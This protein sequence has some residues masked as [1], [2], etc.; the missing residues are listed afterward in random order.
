MEPEL[1][2]FSSH[3]VFPSVGLGYQPSHK[4][5]TTACPGIMVAQSMG[6]ANQYL[7]LLEAGT[8]RGKPY[9]SL[10]RWPGSGSWTAQTTREEAH[11][12]D[13]RKGNEMTPDG[14]LLSVR[15]VPS[16]VVIRDDIRVT[17]S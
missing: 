12:T 3:A 13:K 17:S 4:P 11:S 2:T 1:A 9:P 7:V 8:M 14:M 6:V 15:S 10:P 16:R 5:R